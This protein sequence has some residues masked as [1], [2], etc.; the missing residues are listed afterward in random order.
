[1][2]D[3]LFKWAYKYI[4]ENSIS[5]PELTELV[6][7]LNEVQP[8]EVI[9]LNRLLEDIIEGW[10]SHFNFDLKDE[11]VFKAVENI[12]TLSRLIEEETLS[13]AAAV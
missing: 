9:V 7:A 8:L 5:P 6:L 11:N 4:D 2:T 12:T 10:G 3:E 1:M 13:K